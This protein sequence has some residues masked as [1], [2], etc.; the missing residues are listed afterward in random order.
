MKIE[1]IDH[2]AINVKDLD[3]ARE[4]FSNLFGMKFSP[5]VES[6]EIDVVSTIEANGIELVAPYLPD[7]PTAKAIRNRGEGLSLISLKVVNIDEAMAEMKS[8]GIRLVST[9][10][11]KTLKAALYHPG[12]MFGVMI[13]LVTYDKEHPSYTAR[14]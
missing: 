9:L 13:E 1:C 14:K 8:R 7:G 2:V 11:D 4:V 5:V 6:Q 10:Q 3:K 12:D